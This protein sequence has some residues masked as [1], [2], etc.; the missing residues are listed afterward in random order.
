M[1]NIFL[2]VWKCRIF[3]DIEN[4]KIYKIIECEKSNESFIYKCFFP[5][6]S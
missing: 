1:Q 4:V 5:A 3:R 2:L 6:Q